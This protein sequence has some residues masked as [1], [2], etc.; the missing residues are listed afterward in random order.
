MAIT[1]FFLMLL[2]CALWA[3]T[4]QPVHCLRVSFIQCLQT[5]IE[6]CLRT[7]VDDVGHS[8]HLATVTELTVIQTPSLVTGC[9]VALVC[10]ELV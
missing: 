5:T 2:S 9:A 3:E 7:C 4:V 10:A 1:T 8:L 6:L